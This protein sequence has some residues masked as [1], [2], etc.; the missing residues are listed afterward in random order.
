MM[1]LTRDMQP[2]RAK[3]GLGS[4]L[5]ASSPRAWNQMDPSSCYFLPRGSPKQFQLREASVSTLTVRG[6]HKLSLCGPQ[7]HMEPMLWALLESFSSQSTS[8]SQLE[9]PVPQR[10]RPEPQ[11]EV[12]LVQAHRLLCRLPQPSPSSVG[13]PSTRGV[14]PLAWEL[15]GAGTTPSQLPAGAPQAHCFA[16]GVTSTRSHSTAGLFLGG[17]VDVIFLLDVTH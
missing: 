5:C 1:L 12:L 16:S 2:A 10:A 3:L 6:I 13:L 11:S 9:G 17:W 4:S 8:Q 7:T 15:C 14:F